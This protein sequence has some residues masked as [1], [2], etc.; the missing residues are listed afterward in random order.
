M[1]DADLARRIELERNDAER[2]ALERAITNIE[3]LETTYRNDVYR[4]A[5]K[6]AVQSIRNL[7]GGKPAVNRQNGKSADI[8]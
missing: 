8:A 4:K 2:A 1:T 5:W 6:V 7:M 3:N